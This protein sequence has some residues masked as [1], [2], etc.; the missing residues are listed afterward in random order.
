MLNL[1][2]KKPKQKK[3]GKKYWIAAVFFALMAPAVLLS[4]I[5]SR[6]KKL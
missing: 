5:N 2:K 1:F 6:K 4:K 3:P